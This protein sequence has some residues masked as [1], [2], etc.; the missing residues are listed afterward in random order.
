MRLLNSRKSDGFLIFRFFNRFGHFLVTAAYGGGSI[1]TKLTSKQHVSDITSFEDLKACLSASF[2]GIL[3]NADGEVSG[4]DSPNI[5]AQSKTM[6]SQ[7]T[8]QCYGGSHDLHAKDTITSWDKM[9]KWKLSLC[10]KPAMLTTEM[11][12]QPSSTVISCLDHKKDK[13]SYNALKDLL[14][15]KFKVGK[16]KKGEKRKKLGRKPKPVKNL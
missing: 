15:G 6:L 8:F 13:A 4:S 12:L 5:Q 3:F 14:G 16:R 9:S 11:C 2:S 10:A 1:E 7:S